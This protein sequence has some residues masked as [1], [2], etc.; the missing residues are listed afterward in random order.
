MIVEK[1]EYIDHQTLPCI[2]S[3]K[4]QKEKTEIGNQ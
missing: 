4:L 1:K 2:S 3:Q